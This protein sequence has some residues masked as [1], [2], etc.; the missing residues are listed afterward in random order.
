MANSY[1][2]TRSYATGLVFCFFVF[3]K[4]FSVS[5]VVEDAPC[6]FLLAINDVQYTQRTK[7]NMS[8]RFVHI[9]HSQMRG[10]R[11]LI[12]K[13][14][15]NGNGISTAISISRTQDIS[16]IELKTARLLNIHFQMAG[17]FINIIYFIFMRIFSSLFCWSF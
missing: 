8:M 1:F 17:Y 12:K 10:R 7:H 3:L 14:K 4:S 11:G 5:N 2:Y 13:N 9:H 16:V 15:V 6:F